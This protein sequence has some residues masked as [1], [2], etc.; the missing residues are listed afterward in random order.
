MHHTSAPRPFGSLLAALLL[1]A[2]TAVVHADELRLDDGRILVG[3]VVVRGDQ[4]EVAT[5]DGLVR[6]AKARVVAHRTDDELRRELAKQVQAADDSAFAR[7]ELAKRAFAYGLDRELWRLLDEALDKTAELRTRDGDEAAARWR[8]QDR[9]LREF[10]AQLEPEVLPRKDRDGNTAARVRALLDRVRP[11]APNARREAVVELLS[12]EPGA[13]A[14]LRNAARRSGSER[15]RIA[16]LAALS[17]RD[18]AGNDR[19]VMRSA[20]LDRAGEVRQAATALV[21]DEQ[22]A[23]AVEYL[24]PGLMHGQPEVRVRTAEALGGLGNAAALP[25]LVAAA[26][27]AGKALAAGGGAEGVR[28]H[29]SIINQQAYIRDFDVEIASA[30]FIADPKVDV[31]SSGTVLDVEVMGVAEVQRILRGYRRAIERVAGSDPGEDPRR[32]AQWLAEYERRQQAARQVP[33]A[34]TTPARGNDAK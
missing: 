28:A 32:W 6:V 7:L 2:L 25:V 4:L 20:I 18:A 13:D 5:R 23:A 27:F 11:D 10:L 34:G 31:L 30:S 8:G 12:R 17:R 29:I 3:S 33:A 1:P 15:A 22:R 21:P 19:F 14:E 9:R 26:P 24:A 16:A